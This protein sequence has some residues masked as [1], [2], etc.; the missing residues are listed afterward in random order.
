MNGQAYPLAAG[1]VGMV[2]INMR[3][4][5]KMIVNLVYV[6]VVSYA[7]TDAKSIYALW[8]HHV[9]LKEYVRPDLKTLSG[10]IEGITKELAEKGIKL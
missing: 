5:P 1:N 6:F 3:K 2:V 4:Q 10:V 8:E 9:V 7:I